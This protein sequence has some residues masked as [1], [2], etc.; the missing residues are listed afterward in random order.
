MRILPAR[1][2]DIEGIIALNDRAGL[3][4]WSRRSWQSYIDSDPWDLE[5]ARVGLETVMVGFF[6]GLQSGPDY[7]LLKIGVEEGSRRKGIGTALLNR[8]LE[9][10]VLRGCSQCFLEVRAED[11]G[12]VSFYRRNRFEIRYRRPAY[13]RNPVDDALVLNRGL[14]DSMGGERAE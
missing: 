3:E 5:L 13:Y 6:L 11:E 4:P 12:A 1:V 9:R 14:I 2:D 8:S 10:A 7:E